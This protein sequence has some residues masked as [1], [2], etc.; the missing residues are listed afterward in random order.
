ML[1]ALTGEEFP[2][3][4]E[5]RMLEPDVTS[6]RSESVLDRRNDLTPKDV[7]S[8]VLLQSPTKWPMKDLPVRMP[9]KI[10][11]YRLQVGMD[12][13]FPLL[14]RAVPSACLRPL[15]RSV[16][17]LE[18]LTDL[19]DFTDMPRSRHGIGYSPFPAATNRGEVHGLT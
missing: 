19:L 11:K 4:V 13:D 14:L 1:G 5:P 18:G 12:W 16:A 7:S 8:G 15:N 10:C 17:D 2:E 3:V 9:P 6:G